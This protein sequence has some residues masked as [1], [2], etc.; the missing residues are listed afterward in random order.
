MPDPADGIGSAIT[1]V[2]PCNCNDGGLV[3][4]VP[5]PAQLQ[6]PMPVRLRVG[7]RFVVLPTVERAIEWLGTPANDTRRD[8]MREPLELLLTARDSRSH[9]DIR[10]GYHALMDGVIRECLVFR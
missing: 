10:T 3:R 4:V 6:F 9:A 8:R 5:S 1:R 2:A 7:D